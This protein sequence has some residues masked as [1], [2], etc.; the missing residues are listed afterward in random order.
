MGSAGGGVRAGD[1]NT[2]YIDW[3]VRE[4]DYVYLI[5]ARR[6]E[7]AYREGIR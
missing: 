7:K 2:L 6:T 1:E 3:E 4:M 5:F